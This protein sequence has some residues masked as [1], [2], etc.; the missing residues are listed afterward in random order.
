MTSNQVIHPSLYQIHLE[1]GAKTH[2]FGGWDMP[3]EYA[4]SGVVAEHTAT[5]EK[6]AVFDVSHLGTALLEGKGAKEELNKIFS[7]DLNRINPGQAQYNL[8]LTDAGGIID[9]IFVYLKSEDEILI[10]PNASN[11]DEVLNVLKAHLPNE[12]KI[13]NLHQE[14]SILAVQ[15]PNSKALLQK[16]NLPA[17]IE[18]LSFIECEFNNQ[19]I[20]VCRTGYTGEWGYE[21]LIPSSV[22]KDFWAKLLSAGKEFELIPAGL[23][24]RDTLRTEMGYPLHGQDITKNISPVEAGLMW[25]VGLSKE[26][27]LG[28]LAVES[29]KTRGPKRRAFGLIAVDRAI[30]RM[31][32]KV[33]LDEQLSEEVGAITSGTFSPTLKQGIA[34]ALLDSKL[35]L[36][37]VVYV[38]VRSRAMKFKLV[39]PPFVPSHVR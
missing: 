34:L 18:Y 16:M 19:M 11:S 33:Y 4:S 8:L 25:A 3:M 30:P 28:K 7:N 15:G 5:R 20:T 14:I 26:T 24:A 2:E 38:D 39:K 29:E 17:E 6:V 21:L 1:L 32:M 31:E 27:F 23:G 22:V 35:K 9:D 13:T 10:I 37:Q 36:D 12:I